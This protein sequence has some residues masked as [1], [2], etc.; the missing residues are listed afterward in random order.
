V[1]NRP[2]LESILHV[3]VGLALLVSLAL[4][5]GY[6]INP[7]PASAGLSMVS[8][9]PHDGASNDAPTALD[10]KVIAACDR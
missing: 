2:I 5:A 6:F 1:N 7:P 8:I 4:F 10:V 9:P 3:T